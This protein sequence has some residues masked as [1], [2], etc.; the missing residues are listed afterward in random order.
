MATVELQ[1]ECMLSYKWS[2]FLNSIP[3]ITNA[4][5]YLEITICFVVLCYGIENA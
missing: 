5:C 3:K 2:M 1:V 4:H